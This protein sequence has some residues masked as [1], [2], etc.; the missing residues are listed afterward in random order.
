MV[1]AQCDVCGWSFPS[2][3][4]LQAHVKACHNQL[5]SDRRQSDKF[6]P[7]GDS[8]ELK[9][10]EYCLNMVSSQTLHKHIENKHAECRVCGIRGPKSRLTKA[11]ECKGK[12]GNNEIDW[13][14]ADFLENLDSR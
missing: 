10:C 6:G 9:K 5:L 2:D 14:S 1:E 3:F 12:H 4:H 8:I 11:M 13:L 7:E